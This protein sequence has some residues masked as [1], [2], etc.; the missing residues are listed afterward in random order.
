MISVDCKG[1]S[2]CKMFSVHLYGIKVHSTLHQRI[3]NYV[4]C[5]Y[6]DYTSFGPNYANFKNYEGVL[7]TRIL[8]PIYYF[9]RNTVLQQK[10]LSACLFSVPN[11]YK[12]MLVL[13]NNFIVKKTINETHV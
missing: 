13:S 5:K 10:T 6:L 7:N 2:Q 12:K 9:L 4:S 11:R 1:I 8:Y 3:T